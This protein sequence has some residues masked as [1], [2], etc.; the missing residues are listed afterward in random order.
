MCVDICTY[1]NCYR[2]Q[3]MTFLTKWQIVW[4]YSGQ[5]VSFLSL[6]IVHSSS[7]SA[8]NIPWKFHPN[9]LI[10]TIHYLLRQI[11]K[12][13]F[14]LKK[15]YFFYSETKENT[16]KLRVTHHNEFLMLILKKKTFWLS[17]SFPGDNQIG[18]GQTCSTSL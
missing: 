17:P 11:K 7:P 4:G 6:K 10:I 14:T 3:A 9:R 12:I 8:G 5:G 15:I 13:T 18:W 2:Y 16:E 1:C